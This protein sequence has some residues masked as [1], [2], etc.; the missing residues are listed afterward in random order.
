[1]PVEI[2]ELIIKAT[3]AQDGSQGS[4]PANS[5]GNNQVSQSEEL[6]KTCVDRLLEILKEK[7][8]R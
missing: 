5:G 2:R 7:R 4:T 3:V 1:M 8:E 6:S